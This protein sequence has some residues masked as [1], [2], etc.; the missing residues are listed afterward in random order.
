V[1]RGDLCDDVRRDCA[2]VAASARLVR[3]DLTA[4]I[5]PGS[6]AS[7]DDELHLLEAPAE[8]LAQHVLLLDAINLGSG[9]F[10]TPADRR[11]E[12]TANAITRRLT[13]HA[14]RRGGT[15]TAAELRAVDAGQVAG[16]LEQDPAHDLMGLYARALNQ[17]GVW[18][19]AR[20]DVPPRTLDNWL[21]NR[22]LQPPYSN[23]RAHLTRTVYY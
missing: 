5:E 2:A 22:G 1:A 19:G 18:L 16:L 12:S 9:W 20:D 23:S 6:L 17:L 10:P 11:R 15:W 13:D 14:R 7:L 21:W 3:I 8:E 4:E